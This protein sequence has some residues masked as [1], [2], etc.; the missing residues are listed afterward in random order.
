VAH[1]YNPSYSGGRNQEDHDSKPAQANCSE[2]AISKTLMT[3]MDW[4]SASRC[5]PRVQT[6]VLLKNKKNSNGRSV[7]FLFAYSWVL[8]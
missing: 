6:L 7:S 5:R 1:A 8:E 2:D 4:S 3:K